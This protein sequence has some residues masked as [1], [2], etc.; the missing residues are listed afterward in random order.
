MVWEKKALCARR[1]LGEASQGRDQRECRQ[2]PQND[3]PGM[4]G[5]DSGPACESIVY[6]SANAGK[7]IRSARFGHRADCAGHDDF[8]A[9]DRDLTEPTEK[10]QDRIMSQPVSHFRIVI[11]LGWALALS[12]CH[13]PIGLMSGGSLDDAG[14]ITPAPTDWSFA[15]AA[16][17]IQLET[18]PNAP[19]SVNLAFTVMNGRLFIN[20][21]GTETQWA[22]HIASDA[23][24]RLLMQER[25]Y[26]LRAN[27]VTEHAEIEAFAE[28]WTGQSFFRRDP[29]RYDEV[30]IFDLTKR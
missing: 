26:E 14:P 2:A 24:V 22:K 5:D 15:G 19:Y 4:P 9:E 16:G 7:A 1:D 28:A 23:R 13:G 3:R 20:A 18:N 21:G 12:A 25:I 11:I 17:T 30:W 10:S 27:R 8:W 6:S 29:R